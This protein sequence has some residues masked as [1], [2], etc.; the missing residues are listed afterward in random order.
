MF[1]SLLSTILRSLGA[2]VVEK[3]SEALVKKLEPKDGT[4]FAVP[5]KP[6]TKRKLAEIYVDEL[7]KLNALAAT[8]VDGMPAAAK[9]RLQSAYVTQQAKVAMYKARLD[10]QSTT[11]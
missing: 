1:K 2:T 8:N 5:A 11:V 3:G 6:R 10:S 7:N 4:D 9:A